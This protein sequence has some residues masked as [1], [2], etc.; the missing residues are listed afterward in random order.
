MILLEDI[1]TNRFERNF[2]QIIEESGIRIP[3]NEIFPG[4]YYSFEIESTNF[5]PDR[6]PNTKEEYDY[7]VEKG[8]PTVNRQYVDLNPFGP[9]FYHENWNN[10]VLQLNLKVLP[11]KLRSAVVMSHVNITESDLDRINAFN[12]DE[13]MKPYEMF[14]EG[15]R[16][17]AVKP[18][19][20]ES[21]LGE[22]KL[23]YAINAYKKERINN[24]RLLEWDKIGEIPQAS[25]DSRGVFV[26]R[27]LINIGG[28]FEQFLDLKQY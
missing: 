26:S 23:G 20:L 11:P 27:N 15:L 5:N 13:T 28:L 21:L 8:Y 25:I 12:D 2:N 9:V 18:S 3:R 1:S 4:N 17:C 19:I 7:M 24:P 10:V 6:I 16:I 22:I 14:K